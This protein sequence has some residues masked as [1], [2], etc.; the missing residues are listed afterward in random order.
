MLP[1]L[2]SLIRSQVQYA[3]P[4]WSPTD[5]ASINQLE[6]IQRKFTSKF[7]RFRRYDEELGMTVTNTTY[8]ERLKALKLLSLQRRRERYTIIYMHKIKLGLVPN[9]GFKHDYRRCQKFKFEPKYDRKN[10]RFT[11]F[12]VGPRLYNSIPAELRE[13]EDAIHPDASHVADFK[14]KLDKYLWTLPANPGTQKNSLLNI[15]T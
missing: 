12:V 13:L 10:G 11:F 9:P 8:A 6:H 7:Q 4:I 3:C 2:K 1:L 14:G 15:T 5:S